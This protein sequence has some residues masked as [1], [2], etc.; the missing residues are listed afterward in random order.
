[1]LIKLVLVLLVV[2]EKV[3]RVL[4]TMNSVKI[5]F[6]NQTNNNWINECLVVYIERKGFV[7]INKVDINNA[8]KN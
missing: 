1:M 6:H 4:F 8:F 2:I 5:T 7:V 3:E